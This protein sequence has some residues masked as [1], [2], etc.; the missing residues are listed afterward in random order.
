MPFIQ[1]STISSLNGKPL[2][3]LNGFIWIGSNISSTETDVN[4]HI[5]KAQIA[6]YSWSIICKSDLPDKIKLEFFQAQTV[7]VLLY[8]CTTWEWWNT[9][10]KKQDG[11]YKTADW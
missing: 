1:D 5:C 3:L 4:T 6:T 7:L 11:I 10:K 9:R 2:K 8:P